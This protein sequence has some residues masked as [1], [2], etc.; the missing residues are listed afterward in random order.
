MARECKDEWQVADGLYFGDLCENNSNEQ[1]GVS[2][3]PSSQHISWDFDF[4]NEPSNQAV[5]KSI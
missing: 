1:A 5:A 3:K 2:Q 4:E